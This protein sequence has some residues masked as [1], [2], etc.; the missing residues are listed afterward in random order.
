MALL[1]RRAGLAAAGVTV[2]AALVARKLTQAPSASPLPPDEQAGVEMRGLDAIVP[3]HPPASLPPVSF[4]T[5][6]GGT[7][8]LADYAGR[9]VLLNLWA[10]W[11]V[12]CVAELPGLDRL[13]AAAG[14]GL[15]VVAVATDRGGAAVV[16][17]FLAAHGITHLTVLLDA[18]N[19]A[20][21]ALEVAGFPTTLLIGADG[22]LR[23]TLQGP[24]AWENAGPSIHAAL[25]AG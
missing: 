10:T 13:A 9:G 20:V 4:H 15:A 7:V 21:H 14:T 23:G 25:A 22:K 1:T 8:S 2:A 12:P 24:A 18:S 6:D 5:M 3:S 19:D 16:R 17:P 11:C